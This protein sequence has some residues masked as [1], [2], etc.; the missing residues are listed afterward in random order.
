MASSGGLNKEDAR[1]RFLQNVEKETDPRKIWRKW[2]YL[3]KPALKNELEEEVWARVMS[4]CEKGGKG[5]EKRS[6][7]GRIVGLAP[8]LSDE[9]VDDILGV[10][11]WKRLG[12]DF[13]F[14]TDDEDRNKEILDACCQKKLAL[15]Y[16]PLLGGEDTARKEGPTL[17]VDGILYEDRE[18]VTEVLRRVA[19]EKS[20]WICGGDF[21]EVTGKRGKIA[22]VFESFAAREKAYKSLKLSKELGETIEVRRALSEGKYKAYLH[23]VPPEVG[24]W[25]LESVLEQKGVEGI[26][27]VRLLR[28][29]SKAPTGRAIVVFA[30]RSKLEAE[31][32]QIRIRGRFLRHR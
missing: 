10:G 28:D 17:V 15:Y 14:V 5:K 31:R 24:E 22:F 18:R 4:L 6:A 25:E 2:Y 8:T 27:N 1:S 3:S 29:R 13:V 16:P 20:G 21:T 26:T 23:G 32:I 30:E 11:V 7:T 9:E 12:R 19:G